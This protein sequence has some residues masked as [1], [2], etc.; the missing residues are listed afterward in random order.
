MTL[1]EPTALT[2]DDKAALTSGENFWSTKAIG[3]IPAITVSDG[4]HGLRKPVSDELSAASVPATCFPPAA[5][6]A[7]SWDA[8]L[9]GRVGVALGE[10][11]RTEGVAV[12]LGPGVNIKRSPLGGR[13]FEYY[14]EDPLLT[15]AW[16]PRGCGACNRGGSARA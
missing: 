2:L 5:G 3:E 10:E 8:E 4:P 9:I 11:C 16:R 1:E 14:S 6:L 12:L 7:Q 13:N 15:G